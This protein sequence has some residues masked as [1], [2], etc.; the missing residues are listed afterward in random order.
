MTQVWTNIQKNFTPTDSDKGNS[1]FNFTCVLLVRNSGQLVGRAVFYLA[2][3]VLCCKRCVF[4]SHSAQFLS[5]RLNSAPTE[6]KGSK[7]PFK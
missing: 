1:V 4:G 6:N 5:V 3:A 2:K 7:L